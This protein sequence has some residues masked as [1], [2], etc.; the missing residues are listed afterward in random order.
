MEL[1]FCQTCRALRK[2][3]PFHHLSLPTDDSCL[4]PA[5]LYRFHPFSRHRWSGSLARLRLGEKTPLTRANQPFPYM[6]HLVVLARAVSPPCTKRSK[7]MTL[8]FSVAGDH[9]FMCARHSRR[10]LCWRFPSSVFVLSSRRAVFS[11]ADYPGGAASSTRAAG[12][13]WPSG[14]TCSGGTPLR[15]T[16]RASR[17]SRSRPCLR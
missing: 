12:S 16:P 1:L 8:L 13:T 10:A 4:T 6:P 3:S 15:R 14:S 17:S 2:P 9:A 5:V 11:P 7:K